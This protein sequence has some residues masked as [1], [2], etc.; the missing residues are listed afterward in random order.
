MLAEVFIQV[1]P[2]VRRDKDK[3]S[4]VSTCHELRKLLPQVVFTEIYQYDSVRYVPARFSKLEQTVCLEHEERTVNK[5]GFVTYTYEEI[6]LPQIP[7]TVTRLGIQ[8]TDEN[9]LNIIPKQV[10]H[11]ILYDGFYIDEYLYIPSTVK[12]LYLAFKGWAGFVIPN[13]ITYLTTYYTFLSLGSLPG[14]IKRLTL[15]PFE[16]AK[17]VY[18][19]P[20]SVTH[21]TFG[22]SYRGK[23]PVIGENVTHLKI[24]CNM[25]IR[26]Y[27]CVTHLTFKG[28]FNSSIEEF[29]IPDV[30][31]LSF[32]KSY[33]QPIQGLIPPRLIYL[34]YLGTVYR[35]PEIDQ[36]R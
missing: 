16:R 29:T 15:D 32:Y 1:L 17:I 30:T 12:H 14:S 8:H 35:G 20:K 4:L 2:Y 10:T 13:T 25:V 34:R 3:L 31:H 7:N 27:L 28:K 36:F 22:I 21:L 33:N 23:V 6:S 26:E 19:I 18:Y 9:T 5:R 11:L 24:R